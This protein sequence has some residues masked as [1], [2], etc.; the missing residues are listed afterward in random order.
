MGFFSDDIEA[1]LLVSVTDENDGVLVQ[2][3]SGVSWD[4][5]STINTW[6]FEFS[7][8]DQRRGLDWSFWVLMASPLKFVQ[9][10]D[11]GGIVKI[12]R[13]LISLKL[14]EC[15]LKFALWLSLVSRIRRPRLRLR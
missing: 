5:P 14:L 3:Y 2:G 7:F 13:T 10:I 15:V 12:W 6:P 11:F 1:A 4:V 8:D 9:G